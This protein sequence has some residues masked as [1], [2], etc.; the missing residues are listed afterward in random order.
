[1]SARS[2]SL[3]PVLI[4]IPGCE[5]DDAARSQLTHPAV[6]GVVLFSRNFSDRPQLI[7]LV[8]Q[9]RALRQPRLLVCIDQEGGRVQRLREGFTRLPALGVL[10]KLERSDPPKALDMAY[11][12]AR[13]MASE[14][15]ACG[16]DLSFA[17]VLDL[18]RGSRVI[19]DRSL[20]ASPAAVT[21]LGRAYLAGMHDAGMKTT[22]K[23][24]PGHG[25]VAP[26]SHLED[27]VDPRG[28]D[29]IERSDLRPFRELAGELDALMIAHVVYP[30]V[31]DLPAGYSRKWLLDHLRGR[32]GYQ[33]VV[34]S[35]DLGM[36]AARAAGD[37]ETR[38][39][40]CLAAGC[41]LVLVCQ[42][43]DVSAL[44]SAPEQPSADASAAVARLYGKPT[45]SADELLTA[46]EQGVGEWARWQRSLEELGEQSWI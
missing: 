40:L 12:H 27:V 26:D 34:F 21:R 36:H 11:R 22:G 29:E 33:G 7:R 18:D 35:D 24:F 45:V 31:D 41:D 15:L 14:M 28:L 39:R 44:L 9:I 23:H 1:M 42:P 4:G 5:L 3:G 16:I 46:R 2:S 10:G 20:G 19:G 8:T 6:G 25:S 32:C 13:V 38:S 37:L 43:D 30:A 17:P